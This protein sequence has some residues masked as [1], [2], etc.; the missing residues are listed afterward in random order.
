VR[1]VAK[2][3]GVST[4]S[5]YPWPKLF[6]QPAKVVHAVDAQADDILRLKCDLTKVAEDRDTLK[7]LSICLDFFEL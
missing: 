5:I 6:S 1:E 4:K 7:K 3:L 2:R